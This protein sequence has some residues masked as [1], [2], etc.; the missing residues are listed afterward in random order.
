MKGCEQVEWY[1]AEPLVKFLT[2][3]SKN[4]I[5]SNFVKL[6]FFLQ[7]LACTHNKQLWRTVEK[8]SS[9][10]QIFCPRIKKMKDTNKFPRAF[11]SKLSPGHVECSFD[12]TAETFSKRPKVF[13]SKSK[14]FLKLNF[15]PIKNISSKSNFVDT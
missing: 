15:F 5:Y 2:R 11:S 7:F 13:W 14:D 4:I 12:S 8:F 6:I 3:T 1:S 9:K 10:F